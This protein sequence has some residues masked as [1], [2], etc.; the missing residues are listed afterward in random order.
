MTTNQSALPLPNTRSAVISRCGKYRYLLRR[1]LS[2]APKVATFIM[3]NPSK[4]NAEIDD[5]TIR[6]CM[7]FSRLWGCGEL[8]VVNLFG[9][10]ATNPADMLAADDPVGPANKDWV[11]HAI[12]YALYADNRDTNAAFRGP[13]VCA[14]GTH[15]AYMSQDQAMLG[16]IEA[17]CEPVCLG[18]TK[19]GH[20]KHPLYVPY[21]T[22]MLPFTGRR[23]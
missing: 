10:R 7:G 12:D 21:S 18:L 23:P 2:A 8:Q 4:A 5:P 11:D 16:W 9:I 15:G 17:H 19:G 22:E 3:L 20:P 13:V 1:H 6:K 14:W